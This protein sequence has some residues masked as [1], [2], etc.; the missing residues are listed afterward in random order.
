MPAHDARMD[1]DPPAG[2]GG[3]RLSELRFESRKG[4]GTVEGA[5]AARDP[6]VH[7]VVAANPRVPPAE[8][9]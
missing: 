7:E 5:G 3:H 2:R 1:K 9:E 8:N 6:R 4:L